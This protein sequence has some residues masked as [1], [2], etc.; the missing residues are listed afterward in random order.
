MA[1]VLAVRACKLSHSMLHPC[2]LACHT[3]HWVLAAGRACLTA[4]RKTWGAQTEPVLSCVQRE[5]VLM[6]WSVLKARAS[7]FPVLV[8]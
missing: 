7:Q 3:E 4:A 1:S 8:L 2:Q 5:V 6:L